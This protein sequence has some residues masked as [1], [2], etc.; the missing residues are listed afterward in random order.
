MSKNPEREVSNLQG[1]SKEWLKTGKINPDKKYFGLLN[2]NTFSLI[3]LLT[4]GLVIIADI[5]I[6]YSIFF[7]QK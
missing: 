5:G 2:K 3:L 1:L 4:L 7:L 6:Y